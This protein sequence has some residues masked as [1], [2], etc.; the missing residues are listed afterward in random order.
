MYEKLVFK[1]FPLIVHMSPLWWGLH[2]LTFR[3][4]WYPWILC[5]GQTWPRNIYFFLNFLFYFKIQKVFIILL[6]FFMIWHANQYKREGRCDYWSPPP[7]PGPQI[8]KDV[9]VFHIWKT[10]L[11]FFF[12]VLMSP[13][14]LGLRDTLVP[15]DSPGPPKIKK[16]LITNFN[17]ITSI[18]Y[19]LLGG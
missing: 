19:M 4:P 12:V 6:L 14:W 13:V 17:Q 8:A 10:Y 15:L 5:M 9:N 7:H 18:F 1:L 2:L 3:Y 11:L 16:K